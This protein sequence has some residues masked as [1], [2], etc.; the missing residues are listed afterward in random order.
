M[1]KTILLFSIVITT[2]L[3]GCEQNAPHPDASEVEAKKQLVLDL[4]DEYG[5]DQENVEF[6]DQ[7]MSDVENLSMN[8]IEVELR[9]QLAGSIPEAQ[10]QLKQMRWAM[11]VLADKREE[12]E[13]K[14]AKVDSE[15]DSLL[16]ML[17]Y[18]GIV[19]FHDSTDLRRVGIIK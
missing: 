19:T 3:L 6:S 13:A 12:M 18:P 1:N 16:I 11:D 9:N 14:L 5:V 4:F 17:E 15:R 2:C 7:F 10:K 8:E